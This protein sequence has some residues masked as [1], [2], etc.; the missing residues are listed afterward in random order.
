MN[1][2]VAVLGQELIPAADFPATASSTSLTAS[3]AGR[4]A[5]T[6]I[7]LSGLR[8]PSTRAASSWAQSAC[9]PIA[10]TRSL[11]DLVLLDVQNLAVSHTPK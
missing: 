5:L 11:F 6:L 10:A 8:Q 9:C 7:E 4:T 1:G 2:R 3:L